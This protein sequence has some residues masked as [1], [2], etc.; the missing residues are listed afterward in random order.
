M[1]LCACR[2]WERACSLLNICVYV[3]FSNSSCLQIA[4]HPPPVI[5]SLVRAALTEGCWK[6][7]GWL[8]MNQKCRK[9]P[10]RTALF[11]RTAPSTGSSCP[12]DTRACAMAAS[13]ISSSAQCAGSS[14]RSLFHFAA[15][16]SKMRRNRPMS[17]KMFFLEEF[18]NGS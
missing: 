12:A 7:L 13:S 11:A 6:K 8:E 18:F 3:Y 4:L 1:H 9:K 16:R 14:C 2:D 17:C 15:K 10:A 5:P